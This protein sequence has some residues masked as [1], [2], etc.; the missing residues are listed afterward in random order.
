MFIHS[1]AR[2]PTQQVAIMG[3]GIAGLHLALLLQKLDIPVTLYNDRTPEQMRRSRLPNTVALTGATRAHQR[4]LGIHTW[5]AP[6]FDTVQMHIHVGGEQPLTFTGCPDE[7]L[8]FI[9]MRLYLPH[10]LDLFNARGGQMIIGDYQ[11]DDLPLLAD[12]GALVV[13]ATGR[14]GLTKLFPRI[15][16][17]SPYTQPQRQLMAGLFRGIQPLTP[18]AM[19]FQIAPGQGE[20]FE[21][22]FLTADG[23]VGGLLIEALPGS[24]LAEIATLPYSRQP[25]DFT[26]RLL[27]CL[28]RYAPL[29]YHRIDPRTFCLRHELDLLQGAIIP[30][31]RRAYAPL[32]NYRFALA[33][34]DTH[35]IQDPITGQGANTASH[36]AWIVGEA[37]AD[38]FAKPTNHE[39][40]D[41]AFCQEVERR[42]W[43]WL[44]PV[45]AWSN[46]MLQPPSPHAVELLVAASQT[47]AIADAF[48]SNFN[49]PERNWAIF[50]SPTRMASFLAEFGW[51][52]QRLLA[53]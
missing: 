53:A 8:L 6:C 32:E 22:R 38:A 50:S 31:V 43:T 27:D 49:Y 21:N 47:P 17:A 1:T 30:T 40:F 26:A 11:A 20:I 9:D 15:P 41:E 19:C 33:L 45:T 12:Q 4:E 39:R 16:A 18:Q 34:G 35:V 14:N 24:E 29:T 7:P 23:L 36:C 46:T 37:I 2:K 13:V 48:V 42:L 51:T 52:G 28:Q 44:E 3:A 25:A 5:A 10:L